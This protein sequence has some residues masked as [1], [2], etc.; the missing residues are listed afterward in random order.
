ME[1]KNE[2]QMECYIKNKAMK[3]MVKKIIQLNHHAIKLT[4]SRLNAI[5]E[6]KNDLLGRLEE[7]I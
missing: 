4:L 1:R 5:I 3:N 7:V 6:V 2:L